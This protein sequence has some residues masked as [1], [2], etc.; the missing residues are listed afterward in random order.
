[1]KKYP[2][3]YWLKNIDKQ[4]NS[5]LCSLIFQHDGNPADGAYYVLIHRP[6]T[7]VKIIFY[8]ED[9]MAIFYKQLAK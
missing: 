7:H 6:K 1:M 5:G 4:Q 9:G 3:K 2:E 8:D